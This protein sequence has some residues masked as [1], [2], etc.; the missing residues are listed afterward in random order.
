MIKMGKLK[1][2]ADTTVVDI[3]EFAMDSRTWSQLPTTVEYTVEKV[4][5]GEGGFRRAYKATTNHPKFKSKNWVLKRYLS[6]AVE[7]IT[8]TGV[9][10]KDHTKKAVQM[11]LLARNLASQLAKC[12]T[13]EAALNFGQTL[14]YRN[15]YYGETKD[16]ECVTIEEFIDGKFTKYLNNNGMLCVDPSDAVGQKAECLTHFS[17]AKSEGKLLLVDIQGSGHNLFDPEIA[18][19]KLYDETEMLFCA[20]NLSELA[21]DNFLAKHKCNTYCNLLGLQKY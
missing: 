11:H 16:N 5:V 15:V 20:G 6:E 3:Y 8:N 1:S 18:S 13:P 19:F 10:V 9:S 2:Q 7:G 4:P 17:H 12:L 14:Q 21:F